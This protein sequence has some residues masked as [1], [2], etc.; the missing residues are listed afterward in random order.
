MKSLLSNT[1]T[2]YESRGTSSGINKLTI[3]CMLIAI[4]T[5]SLF[6]VLKNNCILYTGLSLLAFFMIFLIYTKICIKR[7]SFNGGKLLEKTQLFLIDHI[8]WNGKGSILDIGCSSGAVSIQCAKRYEEASVTGVDSW[9]KRWEYGKNACDTNATAEGVTNRIQFI[10]GDIAQ[11]AFS[12]ETFDASISNFAFYKEHSVDD[13][14]LLIKEALRILKRGGSFAFQDKFSNPRYYKEM[15]NF[16]EELKN[17]GI[18]EIHYMR[19]VEKVCGFIPRF[20]CTPWML[21]G[22][23][24]LYGVK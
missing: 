23:G 24:L 22:T 18:T 16:I 17:S 21:G 19:N 20:I 11:L 9:G 14:K 12:D 10:H 4:L 7:L 5:G 1:N 6:F 2:N 13:R 3:I 15:D 8:F